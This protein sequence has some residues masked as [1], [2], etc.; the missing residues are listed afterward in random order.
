[1]RHQ[2]KL[3]NVKRTDRSHVHYLGWCILVCLALMPVLDITTYGLF[4]AV[5]SEETVQAIQGPGDQD[6]RRA[7]L[8]TNLAWFSV[9]F[10]LG[11]VVLA[12]MTAHRAAGPYLGLRRV[13]EAVRRG[14]LD[15]RV[16]FRQY[17]R[18]E[19]LEESFNGMLDELTRRVDRPSPSAA[20]QLS[21][22]PR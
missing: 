11:V 1:M 10:I 16:H 4:Q 7:A 5:W 17:D 21:P 13:C 2:R 19:E 18:L 14:E 15:E 9:A 22:A 3:S 12:I 20:T 6:L 8:I